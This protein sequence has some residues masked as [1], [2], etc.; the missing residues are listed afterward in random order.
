MYVLYNTKKY[1]YIEYRQKFMAFKGMYIVP[2]GI[3]APSYVQAFN[4]TQQLFRNTPRKLKNGWSFLPA[5]SC[6]MPN[7]KIRSEN[8]RCSLFHDFK[9]HAFSQLTLTKNHR[10]TPE[11]RNENIRS[12]L[13]LNELN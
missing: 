7:D 2:L 12:A 11:N 1:W 8:F 13:V 6:H 9:V 3:L 5:R 10:A 4:V